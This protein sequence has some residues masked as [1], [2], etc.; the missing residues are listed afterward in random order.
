MEGRVRAGERM[1]LVVG[2][3]EQSGVEGF[4]E[5]SRPHHRSR[6]GRALNATLTVDGVLCVHAFYTWSPLFK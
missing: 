2:G 3:E 4:G 6:A 5:T 1:G